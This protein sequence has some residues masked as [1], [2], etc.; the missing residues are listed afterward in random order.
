LSVEEP[1]TSVAE[2][3][4][5]LAFVY[6]QDV[7]NLERQTRGVR[8]SRKSGQ[9]LGNYQEIRIRRFHMTL[10]DYLGG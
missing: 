10:D 3:D 4:P 9:T 6:D 2:M 7:V 1:F 5:G 8:A